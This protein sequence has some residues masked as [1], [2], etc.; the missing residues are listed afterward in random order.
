M[1][2]QLLNEMKVDEMCKIMAGIHQYVPFICSEEHLTLPNSEMFS[3][4]KISMWETL[5]GGD[6]LT[7]AR[8]RGSIAIRRNHPDD[9]ERLKGLVPTVEDWH[10][11]MTFMKVSKM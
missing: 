8:A 6:Q 3:Y 10:S 4:K 11:R 2:I 1:G 5:F 7:V 9:K